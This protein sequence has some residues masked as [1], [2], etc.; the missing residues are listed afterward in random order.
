MLHGIAA[1]KSSCSAQ[2]CLAM[3]SYRSV[4]LLT[5]LQ[6]FVYYGLM[7]LLYV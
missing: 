5:D 3:H 7:K 1:D 2:T 4:F 6:K